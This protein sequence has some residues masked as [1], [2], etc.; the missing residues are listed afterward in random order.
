MKKQIFIASLALAVAACG[1]SQ[2]PNSN[3]T[4]NNNADSVKSN[5]STTSAQSVSKSKTVNWK[6][7]LC[8]I[9]DHGDTMM[10]NIYDDQNRI[11]KSLENLENG[12]PE[13]ETVYKYNGNKAT[14]TYSCEE[15]VEDEITYADDKCEKIIE[16]NG[17]IYQ[18]D[19]Q[20]RLS[21]IVV[22][23]N[24]ITYTYETDPK[25]GNTI[26]NINDAG[27]IHEEHRDKLNRI[28]YQREIDNLDAY[29]TK[30]EYFYDYALATVE[31]TIVP[32][33]DDG[34]PNPDEAYE[35][36]WQYMVYFLKE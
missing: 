5:I 32:K 7:V 26:I 16:N 33:G 4:D 24:G 13:C 2:S 23:N 11:I 36:T 25:T 17:Q 1:G 19:S 18:Y 35:D 31:N 28:V 22:G 27:V 6:K 34:V 14:V 8:T 15:G 20:D 21:K 9:D 10:L 30:Y 29:S 3:N 12:T